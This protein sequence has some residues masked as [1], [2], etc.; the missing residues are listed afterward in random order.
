MKSIFLFMILSTFSCQRKEI[1]SEEKLIG[2]WE[3]IN[4]KQSSIIL[5]INKTTI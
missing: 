3:T 1:L 5:E 4:E 2:K